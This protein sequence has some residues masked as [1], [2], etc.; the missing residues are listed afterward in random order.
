[1]LELLK[2]LGLGL[3]FVVRLTLAI[4]LTTMYTLLSIIAAGIYGTG[5]SIVT[6]LLTPFVLIAWL[7]GAKNLAG[8]FFHGAFDYLSNISRAM[9]HQLTRVYKNFKYYFSGMYSDLYTA[10]I[11]SY[12]TDNGLYHTDQEKQETAK[13]LTEAAFL[14]M[15]ILI[16]SLVVL[17]SR[18]GTL[19]SI[20][21]LLYI[22]NLFVSALMLRFNKG[23]EDSLS[24]GIRFVVGIVTV[25]L[26]AVLLVV[27]SPVASAL[28][29]SWL[30]VGHLALTGVCW[31]V[32][33]VATAVKLGV[34]LVYCV[35]GGKD[36]LDDSLA[37][38]RMTVVT[39]AVVLSA[40]VSAL[41]VVCVPGIAPLVMAAASALGIEAYGLSV[42]VIA[43]ASLFVSIVTLG[44][45]VLACGITDVITSVN[46]RKQSNRP[47]S[48]EE[49]TNHSQHGSQAH[50]DEKQSAGESAS[51]YNDGK[52]TAALLGS[53]RDSLSA[54]DEAAG[55]S[56]GHSEKRCVI[57]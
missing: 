50:F 16:G 27:F 25:N 14:P 6:I 43:V 5:V 40:I 18:V 41:L 23:D 49:G 7:C 19:F 32:A 20:V 17:I 24:K 13:A 2:K 48:D 8:R 38:Y 55:V 47:Y 54:V 34:H 22:A 4:P 30:G 1:M 51:S 28:L 31:V 10:L 3:W 46:E 39:L 15:L 44:V 45:S 33:G 57:L 53:S 29:I 52:S 35:I 37:I 42:G 36:K 56:D 12:E 9:I 11:K 21:Q 26:V